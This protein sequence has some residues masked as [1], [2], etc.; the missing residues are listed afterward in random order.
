MA[1]RPRKSGNKD[2]TENLYKKKDSRDGKTYYQYR[3]P[4]N[5]KY[6]GMG[7]DKAQA[8]LDA[9]ALNELI[10]Q[11][12]LQNRFKKIAEQ[13]ES[14]SIGEWITMYQLILD[15]Q[16][17]SGEIQLNTYKTKKTSLKSINCHHGHI[18]INDLTAKDVKALI[19]IYKD[20][21]KRR[22]SMVIRSTY[23]DLITE[24]KQA[25][26]TLRA[27]NP[28]ETTKTI[29]VKT[30]RERLVLDDFKVIL[31][32]A[33]SPHTMPWGQ[34]SM[35]LA[36][37][38]GQRREDLTLAQFKRGRDWIPAFE[39]FLRGDKH[40]IHPYPHVHEGQL[41]I[42]QKKTGALIKIPLDLRLDVL[43]LSVGEVIAKCK[44][45]FVASKYMLHHSKN[46][47]VKKV[48]DP[49]H[50]D[51]LTRQFKKALGKTDLTFHKSPPTFHEIRSLSER[52]YKE[53]AIDTQL[54]LG[55]KDPRMTAVYHDARGAEW[56]EIKT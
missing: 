55:H 3:D 6:H 38:T 56:T 27:D 22:M 15:E 21:G 41:W 18:D 17:E 40:P 31:E 49:L 46:I 30:Q 45:S 44:K 11:Q 39:A 32:K 34:N 14:I 54:L 20:Q 51:A 35:L 8:I 16:L 48:G 50:K 52:L 42:V 33:D 53:Q 43:D 25:G 23:I 5:G 2:L 47:S 1:P 4:R 10:S 26:E 13:K 36:I 7:T 24:A 19:D 28:A 12:I 29:T 37:V 9:N